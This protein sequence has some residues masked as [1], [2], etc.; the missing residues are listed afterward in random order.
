MSYEPSPADTFT[1][2]LW[3][4]GNSGRDPF[5]ASVRPVLEPANTVRRLAVFNG[6]LDQP[7]VDLLRGAR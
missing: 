2:S 5:G 7:V 4:V 1:V 6:R 3:T